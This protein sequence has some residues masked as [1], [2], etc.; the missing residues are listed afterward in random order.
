MKRTLFQAPDVA[1]QTVSQVDLLRVVG[2]EL[3]LPLTQ[4]A[5]TANML[6]SGQLT[7]L[8]IE[9]QYDQ[10]E[11]TS[12][13]M[14]QLVDSILFAGQVETQQTRLSLSPTN[15]SS[16]VHA[17]R[18]ELQ[19]I[20]ALYGR[21]IDLSVARSLAPA[22]I[23]PVALHHSLYGLIDVLI[24]TSDDERIAVD[25]RH[26]TDSIVV[27]LRSSGPGFSSSAIFDAVRRMGRA[28]QPI[29]QLPNTTGMSFY[30]AHSLLD[31]MSGA[32]AFKKHANHS[33]S[34]VVSL[35]ISAQLELV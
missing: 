18:R 31:A 32:V 19:D 15:V 4:I 20:A 21:R 26:K 1:V 28:A 24:R 33:R 27:S 13:R 35:P 6:K 17:L 7:G 10:L 29:R 14:I 23:D 25:V 3:K 34:I 8:D 22:A 2:Q 11:A 30:V 16:V 12:R 9:D 5:N